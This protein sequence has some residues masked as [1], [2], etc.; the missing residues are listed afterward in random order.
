M[1]K[2]SVTW[3]GMTVECLPS[4]LSN[5]H[6]GLVVSLA[7][8]HHPINSPL[9]ISHL[10][11]TVSPNAILPDIAEQIQFVPLPFN[12]SQTV[13][14]PSLLHL[15]YLLRTEMQ[16]PQPMNQMF[17]FSIVTVLTLHLLKTFQIEQCRQ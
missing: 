17:I 9:P 8:A 14:D 11:L 2:L 7:I 15:L 5:I 4:A 1:S 12:Y 16:T 3:D 10:H 6:S 13:S